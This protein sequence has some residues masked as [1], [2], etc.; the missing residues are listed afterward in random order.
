MVHANWLENGD[1]SPPLLIQG[2]IYLSLSIFILSYKLSKVFC[3]TQKQH[4]LHGVGSSGMG[5]RR[6]C[7]PIRLSSP[8]MLDLGV[9]IL[10]LPQFPLLQ[11]SGQGK[12]MVHGNF[13]L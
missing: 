3:P 8:C 13:G 5:I 2:R 4:G 10:R 1:E 12:M 9:P 7:F 6:P 11:G